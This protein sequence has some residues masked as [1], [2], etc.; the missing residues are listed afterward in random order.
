MKRVGTGH[1]KANDI[2]YQGNDRRWGP[3]GRDAQALAQAAR[4]LDRVVNQRELRDS[5]E[6]DYERVTDDCEQVH[7]RLTEQGYAEQNRQ[8]LQESDRVTSA[9]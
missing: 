7:S 5:G 8:V 2:R 3:I 4:D 1:A 6:A 9:L